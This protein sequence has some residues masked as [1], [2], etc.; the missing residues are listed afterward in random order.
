MEI[1]PDI[2]AF[3]KEDYKRMKETEK[4]ENEIK[5]ENSEFGGGLMKT[6]I[7]ENDTDLSVDPVDFT[8]E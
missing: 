4:I 8:Y 7:D 3:F 1:T 6:A 5:V 2:K